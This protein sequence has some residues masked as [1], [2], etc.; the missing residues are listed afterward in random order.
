MNGLP[1]RAAIAYDGR[2]IR[3]I[4]QRLLP[5]R[6]KVIETADWRVVA[7]GIRLLAI[8][9]A[10][11]IGVAAA[12]AVAAEAR[13]SRGRPNA[14]TRIEAAIKGLGETR[15]TAVNLFGAL[16]RMRVRLEA[17]PDLA[18]GDAL[19]QEARTIWE[20]D[21]RRCDRI[22]EAGQELI[23]AGARI[24]TICNTGFLAT[25]GIGTALGVVYRAADAGRV[26]EVCVLETRPLLQGARLTAWELT[27]SGIKT[28]L[29]ADGA[30]ANLMRRGIDL[31][32]IG[33]DRVAAN[34]DTANK[35]G[36][37]PLALTCNRFGVPLYVAAPLTTFDP[38]AKDGSAIPVEERPA[39]EV[40]RFAG[41]RT[42]PEGVSVFNPAFDV[43]EADL[44]SAFVTD[45]G[46]IRP[47]YDFSQ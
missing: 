45:V 7:R 40:L 28:T 31:A 21:R 46:V 4:D 23:P 19:E 22:A 15:P 16:E 36:S 13:R 32:I 33:A 39:G 5:G 41:R 24:M 38:R 37:L 1:P 35:I 20:D 44:I 9:G 43:V 27:Q 29:I 17:E 25:A 14:R 26:K 8:R 34:G 2:G 3:F 12:L 10:P 6:L 47:A 11:L 18:I 42:A 30:V